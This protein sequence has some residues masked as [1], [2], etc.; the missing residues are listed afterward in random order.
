[1]DQIDDNKTNKKNKRSKNR[2]KKYFVHKKRPKLELTFDSDDRKEYLTGFQ[3]RKSERKIK[4]KHELELKLKED[5]K[6]RKQQQKERLAKLY[7]SQLPV[8]DDIQELLPAEATVSYELPQQVVNI[9]T[10]D[11]QQLSGSLGLTLGRNKKSVKK[12]D[13]E[14]T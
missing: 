10:F 2:K 6:R 3:K 13:N 4:A 7:D 8:P 12:A 1:M 5:K 11:A 9:T 14:V